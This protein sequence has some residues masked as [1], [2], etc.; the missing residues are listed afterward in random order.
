M[1]HD[2]LVRARE[3]SVAAGWN[4]T[5]ADWAFFHGANPDGC[6]VAEVDGLV[7]GT[8]TTYRYPDEDA[9][10]SMLLV[11][12][13]HRRSGIGR[14]LFENAFD[15]LGDASSRRLDATELGIGLYRSFGF[16]EE[17]TLTRFVRPGASFSNQRLGRRLSDAERTAVVELDAGVWGTDRGEL[18]SEWMSRTPGCGWILHRD[19]SEQ[20]YLLARPGRTFF[21]LGPL[22]AVSEEAAC[23]LI[24][25]AVDTLG[26]CSVGIDVPDAHTSVGRLLVSRGFVARRSFVR[27]RHGARER[28]EDIKRYMAS[29][30]PEL[31]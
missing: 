30:G 13:A 6:L 28:S 2:D 22:C 26:S 18:L 23:L 15:L 24:G 20:G 5:D 3:L 17:Y 10:L 1:V 11:D 21:H 8:I 27:M 31:G 14:R 9:W 12:D 16:V 29:S 7:A 19:D 25:A 4:Q